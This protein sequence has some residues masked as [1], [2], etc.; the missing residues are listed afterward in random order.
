MI[1][2]PITDSDVHA[3]QLQ[4]HSYHNRECTYAGAGPE[5]R[6]YSFTGRDLYDATKNAP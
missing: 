6:G 3:H 5:M 2:W 1:V 4:K